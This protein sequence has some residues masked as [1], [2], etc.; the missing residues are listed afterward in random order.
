MPENQCNNQYEFT[1]ENASTTS[2][3]CKLRKL[4]WRGENLNFICKPGSRPECPEQTLTVLGLSGTR[5]VPYSRLPKK[6]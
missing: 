3:G 6:H 1:P 2:V 4:T 5:E